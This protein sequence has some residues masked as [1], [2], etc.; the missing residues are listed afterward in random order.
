MSRNCTFIVALYILMTTLAYAT[1][2]IPD[3]LLLDNEKLELETNPLEPYLKQHPEQRPAEGKSTGLWRGYIA[4]WE[5]KDGEL[6]LKSVGVEDWN[7]EREGIR[8][9][10]QKYIPQ[11]PMLAQW[12]S[13]I[14]IVPRGKMIDYVHMG[15]GSTYERYTLLNI[16]SGKLQKR[17]DLSSSEFQAYRR[18]K[19]NQFKA[20]DTYRKALMETQQTLKGDGEAENFLFSFYAEMYLSAPDPDE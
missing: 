13:G 11:A 15:Y 14:L 9:V 3:L 19:F 10:T 6:R 7:N 1:A 12:F 5:I 18:K 2:Q 4:T 20:T 8:D 17:L 16:K